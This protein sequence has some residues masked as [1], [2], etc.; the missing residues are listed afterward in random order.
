MKI[1]E[2]QTLNQQFEEA[3]YL[4]WREWGNEDNYPFYKDCMI[5]SLIT[6]DSLPHFYI[7]QIDEKTIGTF[8]LLRNDLNSRQDLYPWLACLFIDPKHRG[9]ALGSRLLTE[10]TQ[11][12]ADKGYKNLYLT[13]DLDG[14]Y[15]KYGWFNSG[16]A[17]GSNGGSIKLYEKET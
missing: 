6:K 1:I 7:A 8:A 2:L 4:Y 16:L 11:L 17:Y 3:V 15:E 9:N 13:S 14:Y 12:A 5:H 10:A